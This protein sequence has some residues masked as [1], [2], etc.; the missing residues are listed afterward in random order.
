[1]PVGVISVMLS[2]R[3]QGYWLGSALYLE[4][5]VSRSVY[6]IRRIWIINTVLVGR[7]SHHRSI[8]SMQLYVNP[9]ILATVD[10]PK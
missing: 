4:E 7:D 5:L 9:L 2:S 3:M 8:L 6:D 10:R 1:M